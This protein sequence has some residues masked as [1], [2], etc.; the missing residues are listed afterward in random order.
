MWLAG[1][2]HAYIDLSQALGRNAHQ[3]SR[4]GCILPNSKML[5]LG[6]SLEDV[7]I[8]SGTHLLRLQGMFPTEDFAIDYDI[9]PESVQVDLAGNAVCGQC[10]CAS[11]F[12]AFGSCV[13][14]GG[15]RER[16]RNH[17]VPASSDKRFKR[18]SGL[19]DLFTAAGC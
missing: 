5:Q 18:G 16:R 13:A 4:L 17:A 3:F 14:K 12:S 7:R 6:S 15:L 2:V 1:K 10:Y 8:L 19:G 9:V 11:L